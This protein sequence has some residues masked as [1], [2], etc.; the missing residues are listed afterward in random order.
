MKKIEAIVGLI[1]LIIIFYLWNTLINTS[2]MTILLK[3]GLN[4]FQG[5]IGIIIWTSFT[6]ILTYYGT[7][8]A[9]S[10]AKK[11]TF[12]KNIFD[13]IENRPANLSNN[14]LSEE[15]HRQK[16]RIMALLMKKKKRDWLIIILGFAPA[17]I[18]PTCVIIAN[19]LTEVKFGLFFLLVGNVF[20]TW[21]FTYWNPF[22]KWFS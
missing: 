20:R 10:W 14:W 5:F 2:I 11:W 13:K 12:M 15:N 8:K 6:L 1:L 16:K 17:P 21:I 7:A 18:I 9:K 3:M 19:K 4:R 22:T